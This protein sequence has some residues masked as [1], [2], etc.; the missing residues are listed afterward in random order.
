[1]ANAYDELKKW[2]DELQQPEKQEAIAEQSRQARQRMHSAIDIYNELRRGTITREQ[3]IER[4]DNE[5]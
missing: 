2:Y 1:M 3:A 4:I 5:L